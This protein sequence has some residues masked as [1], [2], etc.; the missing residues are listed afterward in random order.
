MNEEKMREVRRS[1]EI[2]QVMW[3]IKQK[4]IDELQTKLDAILTEQNAAKN[5]HNQLPIEPEEVYSP[6][7]EVINDNSR[8]KCGGE[9]K[10]GITMQNTLTGIPDFIGSGDV[11][12]ISPGGSGKLIECRKCR[13]CGY[14]TT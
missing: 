12:T 10:R 5:A 11:I 9:M 1:W 4:E 14:S 7:T 6:H 3:A 8:R 2:W 13:D